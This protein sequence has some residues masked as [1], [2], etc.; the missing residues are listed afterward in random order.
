MEIFLLRLLSCFLMSA[1]FGILCRIPQS[2]LLWSG[3]GGALCWAVMYAVSQ[4]GGKLVAAVFFGS[5]ALG[6]A[7]EW[8]AR[9]T[10]KPAT[11][12][13]VTGFIPLVP[14]AE[15]TI[16]CGFLWKVLTRK[17]ALWR[18]ACC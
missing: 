11:I 5:L 10:H 17:L 15:V 12:Y 3:A 16:R 8:L 18:C 7:A 6:L 14:G 13:I 2:A 4:A 1:A 9:R